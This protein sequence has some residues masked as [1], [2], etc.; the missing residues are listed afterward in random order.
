M[1]GVAEAASTSC[2]TV[3]PVMLNPSGPL[4]VADRTRSPS[5]STVALAMNAAT[6]LVT[7]LNASDNPIDTP[8]PTPPMA[9]AMAAAPATALIPDASVAVILMLPTS[10]VVVSTA[11]ESGS[12]PSRKAWTSVAMRFTAYTPAPLTPTAAPPPVS[13]T[14]PATTRASMA[15]VAS[16]VKVSWPSAETFEAAEM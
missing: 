6:S 16:A 7:S 14:A 12:S 8:T 5:L 9:A 1:L 2:A 10:M 13:A 15:W 4:L 11:A 3:T